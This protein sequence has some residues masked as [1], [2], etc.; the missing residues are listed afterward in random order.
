MATRMPLR[1]NRV[2]SIRSYLRSALW[3]APVVAVVASIVLKRLAEHLSDLMVARGVYDRRTGFWAL[4]EAGAHALLERIFTLDLS[5]LVFTFGS[6]LV[7]IQVAGG[8]YTPRVIATTLLRDRAIR[9]IVGL[10]VFT[11]LWTNRALVELGQMREVPQMQVFVASMLGLASLLAFIVLIDYGARALRP[12]TLVRQIGQQGMAVIEAVYPALVGETPDQPITLA[13]AGAA[14]RWAGRDGGLAWEGRERIVRHGD[15]SAIVLALNQQGLA[16]ESRRAG[17]VIEFAPQVGDF[18]GVGEPLFYLYGNVDAIDERRLRAQVA[19]GAERTMEQDPMFAFR[20]EVDIALKALSAA[21][22]DPTT[23]VLVIDQLQRMLAM[24][25]KRALCDQRIA[26]ESGRTGLLL[27][28]PN[29]EDFVHM[30]FRE[31]RHC[32]AGSIQIERRL[33]AM[34]EHLL[35]TLPAHRHPALRIELDLIERAAQ[36]DYPFAEDAALA[37][38]PDSQGLGGASGAAGQHGFQPDSPT[39]H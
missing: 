18:V 30:S 17:C 31:I 35:A 20:I 24:V 28:T 21:I 34:I 39:R 11:L 33:R 10:F 9:A 7:A 32:G 8:Q 14:P 5:C 12:V 3:L 2:Y 16:A 15:R 6:L 37:R 13:P 1:W 19:F 36:R 22:N 29:W 38:I 4:D 27:R 25:G 26:D 23:A